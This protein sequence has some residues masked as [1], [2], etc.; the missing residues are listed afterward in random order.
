MQLPSFSVRAGIFTLMLAITL[1]ACDNQDP[2]ELLPEDQAPAITLV[3]PSNNTLLREV[4]ESFT[5]T[6]QLADNEA[7]ELLRITAEIYD[8]RD[9][10]IG[11]SFLVRDM[12][13]SGT[14]VVMDYTDQVPQGALPYYKVK[15]TA[16]AIDRKGEFS[17]AFFWVSVLPEPATPAPFE[18]RSYTGDSIFND[19]AN[20][21]YAYNFTA[22]QLY[23]LPGNFGSDLDYDIRENSNTARSGLY[24]PRLF[25]P[26]N[27]FFGQDSVFVITDETRFN[28]D[29]ATYETIFNAF[30]SDPMPMPRTP[31]LEVGDIV[32]VR[33]T[34]APQ[35]QFA[36]MKITEIFSDGAGI[37]IG[38]KLFFDYKV[39]AKP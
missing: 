36:V 38:D 11:S 39:T 5:V 13:V 12:E 4:G 9:V 30:F 32:I 20:F 28:Y 7:L 24:R 29:A 16:H 8:Q 22:R 14:N 25:S 17:S 31:E 1:V 10:L 27:E 26:N 15:Y 3:S 6:F 2:I 18:V 23:P 37:L 21:G 34:K 35:P 19:Q 33:L